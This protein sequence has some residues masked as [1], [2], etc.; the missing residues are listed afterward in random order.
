MMQTNIIVNVVS[1]TVERNYNNGTLN[2][3]SFMNN[4]T[5][6]FRKR[7]RFKTCET[8]VDFKIEFDKIHLV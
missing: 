5:L 7:D 8:N 2:L 1:G 3:T 4:M 6:R